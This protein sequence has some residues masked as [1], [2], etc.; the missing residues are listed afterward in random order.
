MLDY[1]RFIKYHNVKCKK[2]TLYEFY[3]TYRLCPERVIQ[4][5]RLSNSLFVRMLFFILYTLYTL[6]N[7][8]NS[9]V[10]IDFRAHVYNKVYLLLKL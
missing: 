7:N 10:K 1:Q 6:Y 3:I 4:L 2:F 5:L 8:V 9:I